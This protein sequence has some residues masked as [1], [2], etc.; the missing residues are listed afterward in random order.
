MASASKIATRPSECFGRRHVDHQL[1][2]AVTPAAQRNPWAHLLIVNYPRCGVWFFW[3][4]VWYPVPSNMGP[5][6]G[7]E[8]G[9]PAERRMTEDLNRQRVLNFL[10][11]FYSG[12]ID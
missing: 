4:I 6:Q 2:G 1:A 3:R 7:S 11:V 12:D 5:M 8:S 9:Q 10:E